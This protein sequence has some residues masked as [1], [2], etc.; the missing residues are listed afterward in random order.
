VFCKIKVNSAKEKN[1]PLNKAFILEDN[2][3]VDQETRIEKLNNKIG[4]FNKSDEN[5]REIK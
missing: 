2:I 3:K 1:P 5:S 4:S